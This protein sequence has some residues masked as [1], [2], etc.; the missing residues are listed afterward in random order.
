MSNPNPE[1]HGDVAP[2]DELAP[3]TSRVRSAAI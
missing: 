2:G 1:S 3:P